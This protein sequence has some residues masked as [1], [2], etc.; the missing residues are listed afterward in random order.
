MDIKENF[1]SKLQQLREGTEQLDKLSGTAKVPTIGEGKWDYP[2]EMTKTKET[3]DM[4]TTNAAKNR[5][6]R[7]KLR[8]KVK[9]KAHKELMGGKK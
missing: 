4:G 1:Y 6:E 8:K 3:S 5:A 7:K 9:A 2:K